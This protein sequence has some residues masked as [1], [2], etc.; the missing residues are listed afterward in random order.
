MKNLIRSKITFVVVVVVI[1]ELLFSCEM[2][3]RIFKPFMCFDTGNFLSRRS[4]VSGSTEYLSFFLW[5]FIVNVYWQ[6]LKMYFV[7]AAQN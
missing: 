3:G 6:A 7:K 4:W 5:K 1:V 2:L